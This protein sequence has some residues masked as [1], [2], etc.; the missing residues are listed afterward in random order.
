MK[1]ST[2]WRAGLAFGYDVMAAA[3]AWIGL[4]WLRFNLDL[5][6]PAAL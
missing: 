2:N 3:L 1:V 4:F 6:E 5:R